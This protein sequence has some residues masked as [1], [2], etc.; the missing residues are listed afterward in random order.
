MKKRS[1]ILVYILSFALMLTVLGTQSPFGTVP[2][3]EAAG[4]DKIYYFNMSGGGAEG[5][6]ML[7]ESNGHWGLVD[8]GHRYDN[9]IEDYNGAIY[10]VTQANGLSSQIYCRNGKDAADYMMNKL[11]VTHLD[12]IV[13]THAHSDHIG[14]VAEIAQTP[15]V[16][17]DTT[18]YY[19]EYKHISSQEDDMFG[20][21]PTSWHNQAFVYQ[22][23]KNM[24]E[25][26]ARVVDVSKQEAIEGDPGNS[27]G[28]YITF[29][30]GDMTFR[31]YNLY[32]GD[33]ENANSI[34]TTLTN[35]DYTV[36][37]LGDINIANDA[38]DNTSQA[39][40]K[41]FGN[42]DIVVAGHHGYSGSNTKKMF[43]TLQPQFVIVSNGIETNIFSTTDLAA[44]LPY[45]ENKYGTSF[46]TTALSNHAIVTD[47]SGNQVWVYNAEDNGA[48]TDFMDKAV[49]INHT[50][51]WVSWLNSGNEVLW[52]YLENGVS[53][54]NG[55]KWVGD[56]CYYFDEDGIMAANTYIDGDYVDSSGAWVPGF[57]ATG[58][59]TGWDYSNGSTHYRFDDGAL[60]SGWLQ[61]DG[62]WYYFGEDNAMRN[63]WQEIDGNLYYFFPFG[64]MA[65]D[66]WLEGRYLGADG[67]W[68][69]A[70]DLSGS[71][72][73]NN[74][75]SLQTWG[76]DYWQ[77]YRRSF[78]DQQQD[79][80]SY[81]D[82]Q[83]YWQFLGD[84]MP[85]WHSFRDQMDYW[86]SI[87]LGDQQQDWQ[88]L[89]HLS[90]RQSNGEQVKDW[91]FLT[92]QWSDWDSLT[93]QRQDWQA[94]T[95]QQQDW[96]ALIGQQQDWQALI[97]QLQG[98][99]TYD[100]QSQSRGWQLLNGCWYYYT[101]GGYATGWQEI[102]GNW[103]FFYDNGIMAA[104]TWVDGY[105]VGSDG[106]W[107]A[108]AVR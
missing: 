90:D 25:Q 9:T 5:S 46:Y 49:Q 32:S 16:D 48:L 51:G 14:G 20:Y 47:L 15:L 77:Q 63:G 61:S 83:Q 42:V 92:D 96:Q 59:Q 101:A 67:A 106:A 72:D 56:K 107:V 39:I 36:V 78:E 26:G 94:L 45:L 3:A 22:A 57:S 8:T 11:G 29:T 69:S 37:N 93:S 68:N 40:G 44:A 13:G 1:R 12:F 102:D 31:L 6:C 35:G 10:S 43:D 74:I 52:S 23:V 86:Q 4:K 17:S 88:S 100:G 34:V 79:W 41:D 60:A 80:Q 71:F 28:N 27:F 64:T 85:E 97:D 19:K 2:A 82:S 53:V 76:D 38:I 99:Q 95:G 18:Y 73:L 108:D 24:Q 21:S 84:Q 65:T 62:N 104:D 98:G 66:I 103:Y 89:F 87:D 55:W 75:R 81:G 70:V 91:Q 54:K 30:M 7:V 50:T 33:D 105:Y 58:L